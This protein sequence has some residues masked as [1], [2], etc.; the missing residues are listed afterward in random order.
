MKKTAVSEYGFINAKLRARISSMLTDEF[1]TALIGADGIEAAVQVL[2]S[3]GYSKASEKWNTTGDIQSLE[4]ELFKNHIANYSM[5]MK[6]TDGSLNGLINVLSIKPE[7]ENIKS[8]LRLWYGSK[9][10]HSPINYRSA[11]IIRERIRENIDWNELINAVSYEDIIS[12]FSSTIY[13]E[14]FNNEAVIDTG[15]SLFNVE[16]L[17]DKLY[18]R[19]VIEESYKLKKNDNDTLNEIIST[20]IDLQN[21]SWII[22]YRHFYK[23]DTSKLSSILIPGGHG[24]NI[25]LMDNISKEEGAGFAPM[26]ILKKSYPELSSLNISNKHNFSAQARLF[27]QLL[28]E[29]RKR[30]FTTILTGYP[31][32]I[33]VVLAY[34]F[35]SE[36]ELRFISSVINGKN[37]KFSSDTI[38]E[39][40]R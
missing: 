14:I 16:I 2:S 6:N 21:V 24:L 9:L 1:K 26:E 19:M 11:Y 20:E 7:I 29:T 15:D 35:I 27:E 8:V 3:Y 34:F 22:R 17:L 36:R 28:D 33:G 30:K 4:F 38:K 39:M 10:R 32:T 31:F 25:E 18:Y 37:Y 23:M 12:V 13:S 5:V 40:I